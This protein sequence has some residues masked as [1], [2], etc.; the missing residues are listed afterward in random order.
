[1][2][3]KKS[4]LESLRFGVKSEEEIA[5][6]A[7]FP[8]KEKFKILQMMTSQQPRAIMPWSILGVFRRKYK[9]KVLALFQEEHGYNKIAED[10]LGRVEFAEVVAAVR[11]PREKE[12]E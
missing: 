8:S 1:M 7:M 12:E 4:I 9:S 10:R 5:M 2:A 11:R 6:E 3:E